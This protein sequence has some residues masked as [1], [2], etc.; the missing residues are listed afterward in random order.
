MVSGTQSLPTG[1]HAIRG[2][3]SGDEKA[4]DAIK[5]RRALIELCLQSRGQPHSGGAVGAKAWRGKK[6]K[7]IKGVA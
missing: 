1:A 7:H 3:E 6:R 4:W 2:W 5:Y